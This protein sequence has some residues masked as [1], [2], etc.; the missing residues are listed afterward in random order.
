[1][2]ELAVISFSP[3]FVLPFPLIPIPYC[4][5]YGYKTNCPFFK[6]QVYQM[7]AYLG[8]PEEILKRPPTTDTYSM[9]QSQDEFYFPLPYD[10]MD[11]CLYGINSGIAKDWVEEAEGITIEQLKR[12]YADI[13]QKWRTS[14]YLH[15]EPLKLLMGN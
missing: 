3:V 12:V 4:S 11:L 15:M 9:P 5:K 13:K 10:K 7:A 14:R 1:M 6:S 8:V 2:E